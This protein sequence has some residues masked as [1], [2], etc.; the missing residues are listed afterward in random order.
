MRYYDVISMSHLKILDELENGFEKKNND[1]FV[2]E[3]T[4]TYNFFERQKIFYLILFLKLFFKSS[5][6]SVSLLL[7]TNV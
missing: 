2:K 3:N 6:I 7:K 4:L 5:D 1:P